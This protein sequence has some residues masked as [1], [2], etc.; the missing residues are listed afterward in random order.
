[1]VDNLIFELMDQH[2]DLSE[3]LEKVAA[4]AARSD[5]TA[6]FAIKRTFKLSTA[7]ISNKENGPGAAPSHQKFAK[8]LVRAALKTG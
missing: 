7:K 5:P 1:M 2:D 4:M 3:Q 8:F 6:L